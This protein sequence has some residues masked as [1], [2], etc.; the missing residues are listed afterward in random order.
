MSTDSIFFISCFLPVAAVIYWLVPGSKLKNWILLI[1]GLIFYSFGSIPG[2]GVLLAFS[3]VNY[4]LGLA[5]K[6][7]PGKVL[8]TVG[9]VLDLGFLCAYK[10]LDFLLSQV[11]GLP[12]LQWSLAAPLGI[13]FFTF[14][15]ICYLVDTYRKPEQ[16]TGSFMKLLLYISFFPQIVAGPIARFS[17][18]APQLESR[19]A[20]LEQ[21]AGGV[22]RFVIGLAKKLILAGTFGTMVDGVFTLESGVL[23]A[24]LAWAGAIGYCLQIYFDFSGYSDMAVGLG[25]IFGFE[26]PENFNYPYIA[27]TIGNFWRRWHMSLSGWFKDYLYIPLGGNRKGKVKAA[28]NKF[29]VFALCGFWHGAS[30]NFLVWGAWHGVLSALESLNVIPAKKLE[31]TRVLGRIYTLLAVCLGFVFFRAAT[32]SQGAQ[33]LGAMFTGFFVT[34][35]ARVAWHS[36]INAE[37]LVMLAAGILFCMPVCQ[38]LKSKQRL[39]AVLEPVSYIGILLLFVL[40]LAKMAAGGF[41]PFIYAQF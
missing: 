2:L 9:I 10:Y 41:S 31:K 25:A 27:P 30:W 6:R 23:N 1:L 39:Y 12:Q 35:A 21:I 32:L 29:I 28:L 34:D 40:C 16:G 37:V 5:L 13:S 8:L 7:K 26:S 19:K 4:L 17:Q 15:C 20:S 22:R 38:W 3:L 33:M 36:L 18:F 24:P 14:K 11:L